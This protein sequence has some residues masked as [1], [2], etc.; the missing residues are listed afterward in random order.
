[1]IVLRNTD[2]DLARNLT[3]HFTGKEFKCKCGACNITLISQSLLFHL[4]TLRR[5]W[6]DNVYL[7][8]AFRCQQH[9]R[10]IENASPYS[11]HQSGKAVDILLPQE[12]ERRI[13]F[14]ELCN[15]IWPYTK[16]YTMHIHCDTRGR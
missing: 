14:I 6:G 2:D 16:L 3:P 12:G 4:E 9:N 13:R 15:A 1:M 10:S 7:T 5:V 8:S 11:W